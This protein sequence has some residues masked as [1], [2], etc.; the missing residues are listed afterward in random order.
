LI[1]S[2]TSTNIGLVQRI[3][4]AIDLYYQHSQ[5]IPGQ[6]NELLLW[7]RDTEEEVRRYA[8]R[9]LEG[10]DV[11]EIGPGQMLNYLRYFALRNNATGIDLNVVSD[12][13]A[14]PTLVRMLRV[15]GPMRTAKTLLRKTLGLDAKFNKELC[16]Q[17]GVAR[18]PEPRVLQMDAETMAFTDATFDFVFSRNT[19]EHLSDPGTVINQINRVL[20]PGGVAYIS[21]D[22]YT[23]ESGC[24]DPRIYSGRREKLP[25]W[26]HLRPE[27]FK[28]V[29][30]NAYLN[31][32]R[33][34]D[35]RDLFLSKMP[36]VWLR[37]VESKNQTL[38]DELARLRRAGELTGFTNEE[39][40]TFELVA[41]WKRELIARSKLR[42][43]SSACAVGHL[44][45]LST[46]I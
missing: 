6:V 11:L 33:L 17:L 30:S 31:K 46:L 42:D 18:L 37:T 21:V 39:L 32:I 43:T 16:R 12:R 8:G 3:N 24:H 13:L 38:R 4:E 35:W 5:N 15:N 40:L 44:S 7:L 27:H 29:Q 9:E 36:D 41:V 45:T 2:Y 22:L 23:S 1:K 19:F 26:S 20:K 10:L 25:L 28:K 34:A 14:L